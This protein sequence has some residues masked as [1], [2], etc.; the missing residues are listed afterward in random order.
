MGINS[1]I[2]EVLPLLKAGGPLKS[3]KRKAFVDDS[4]MEGA[5]TSA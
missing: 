5:F 2:R 4:L 3:K 1:E